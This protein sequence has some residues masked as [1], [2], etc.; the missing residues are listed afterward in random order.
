MALYEPFPRSL[1]SRVSPCHPLGYLRRQTNW[2][3]PQA[4]FFL[5]IVTGALVPSLSF[6]SNSLFLLACDD[7]L[8]HNGLLLSRNSVEH[9][10]VYLIPRTPITGQPQLHRFMSTL[11][12]F[13][14][15]TSFFLGPC[16][17]AIRG[18]F[19][20]LSSDTTLL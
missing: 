16:G 20:R 18:T 4:P 15:R 3:V 13:K 19:A 2:Q 7:W 17:T 5:N 9:V 14:S 11:R 12:S 6:I 10:H 8:Y 1:P